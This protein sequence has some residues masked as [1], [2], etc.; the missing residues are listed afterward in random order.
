MHVHEVWKKLAYHKRVLNSY[1]EHSFARFAALNNVS[2]N[3]CL[4][5][6]L[7]TANVTRKYSWWKI[8]QQKRERQMRLDE[9]PNTSIKS[10]KL[11]GEK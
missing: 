9:E 7:L 5:I 8:E 6:S 11:Q 4:M 10:Y 3:D 1:G 2:R